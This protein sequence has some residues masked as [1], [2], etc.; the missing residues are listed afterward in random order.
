MK[1]KCPYKVYWL[2]NWFGRVLKVGYTGRDINER[3]SEL[4]KESYYPSVRKIEYICMER[5]KSALSKEK[6]EIKKY[7][8]PYNI[9]GTE[10][11]RKKKRGG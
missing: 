2:K 11:C 6:E 7:C 9:Q 8:P 5:E 10:G 1:G 3:L 4:K